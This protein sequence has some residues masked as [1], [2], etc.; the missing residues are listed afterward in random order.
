MKTKIQLEGN[1]RGWHMVFYFQ[2]VSQYP[3]FCTVPKSGVWLPFK[4]KEVML[5]KQKAIGKHW[6]ETKK[7]G[8]N[9]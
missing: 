1:Q 4:N 9:G 3:P 2:P 7:G 6:I 8:K 5:M